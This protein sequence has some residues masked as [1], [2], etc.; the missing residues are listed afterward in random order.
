VA[1]TLDYYQICKNE[2]NEYIMNV[3]PK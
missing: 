1:R 2:N 3:L